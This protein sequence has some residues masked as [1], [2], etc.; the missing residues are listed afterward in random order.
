[1]TLPLMRHPPDLADAVANASTAHKT[2][3]SSTANPRSRLANRVRVIP[4]SQNIR[5]ITV[6]EVTDVAIAISR[7]VADGLP[8]GPVKRAVGIKLRRP[9]TSTK[10]KL[11]K[12]E[13]VMSKIV[14]LR[15]SLASRRRVS[16]PEQNISRVRPN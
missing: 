5:E 8:R 10:P 14:L 1:M 2:I 11:P 16:A 3:S 9:T 15:F 12:S 7:S 4:K 13:I 6:I